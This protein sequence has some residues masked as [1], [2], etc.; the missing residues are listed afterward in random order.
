MRNID[1][2][3]PVSEAQGLVKSGGL[4]DV[5]KALPKALQEL[6]KSVAITL[7]GYQTLPNKQDYECVLS[8]ELEHWPHTAYQVKK[9]E[10]DGVDVYVI[11]CD[12]YFDRPELYAEHNRAYADNGERFSFFSAASLDVLPK[13]GIKPAVVHANDW[14]TSLVP[15]L[16]KTRYGSDDRFKDVKSVLTVHNAIFK[17]IFSYS[18]LEIIPELNL[19]GM[20]FLQYGEGWISMLRAGIAFADKVN[21]VS[22][23]YAAELVTPLGSHGLVDDFVHRAKDLHGIVNGCDYSEWDPRNDEF[24]PVSYEA[25]LASML[26]GKLASKTLLQQE[27]NLPETNVPM[28]GMVC[29][30]TH[31]KGF[32][33]ILPILEKF[34]KNDV[35]MVIIGTGESQIASHLRDVAA[36]YPDKLAFVEAYSNRFAHLVEAG[37]DFFLMPS[38]F[39]ACGL[40]QLYSMAY[41]TLPIIRKVGGLKDTVIDFDDNPSEATGFGFEEPCHDALLIVLQRAL[42]F[43][44]QQ[45][46]E[47]HNIQLR[48]MRRDFSWLESAKEYNKMYEIALH[49]H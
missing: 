2:W 46:D 6:G 23:N 20:E 18:Q 26:K 49:Q 15:F 30:L 9:T 19:S 44:L 37:S 21:A 17:G 42:L 16:L 38:E 40:N 43:Y 5:A 10:L 28:V 8:T 4:A 24:L 1:V 36:E 25:E 41:G 11:E 22:P 12:K 31:Q 39:E 33:Y 35:Q 45:P 34:L 47:M 32:H 29:R 7:P 14:H 13:L 27:L 3:F 48:A